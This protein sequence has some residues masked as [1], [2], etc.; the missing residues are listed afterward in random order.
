MPAMYRVGSAQIRPELYIATIDGTLIEDVSGLIRDGMVE[1]DVDK[2]VP[3]SFTGTARDRTYA[4]AYLDFL[5]PYVTIEY[6]DGYSV[7][8][9]MGLF[10]I[11]PPKITEERYGPRVSIDGRALTWIVDSDSYE[12]G[13]TVD[14]SD[15]LIAE[16][17]AILDSLDIRHL[18]VPSSKTAASAISFDAGTSKLDVCNAILR[19]AGYYSLYALRDG[20]LASMPWR[21]I[22]E[23]APATRY[24][25]DR[26]NRVRVL[27]TLDIEPTVHSIFNRAVVVKDDP[28]GDPIVGVYENT[29]LDSK[30]SI[31]NIGYRITAPTITDSYIAD[32]DAADMRARMAVEQAAAVYTKM[33]LST[34]PDNQR[35][36]HEV[37]ELDIWNAA[38]E[39]VASGNWWCSGWKFPF[40]PNTPMTHTVNKTIPYG[41]AN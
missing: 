25:S 4:A 20:R 14:A 12:W 29:N 15:N 33:T 41:G 28:A 1:C 35:G 37:Y 21:S 2:A 36:P 40:T 18:I 30:I 6:D 3:M 24:S 31:P 38:G 7:R 26:Q 13:Y 32:Q 5:A 39:Q 11:V 27:R 17:Q 9:P 34:R 19:L 16:V 8:E 23:A 22:N 10:A